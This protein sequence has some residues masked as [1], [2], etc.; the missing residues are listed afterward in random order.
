M[1]KESSQ[2][3]YFRRINR[4]IDYIADH[5]EKELSVEE[6]A[7]LSC[8]SHYHFH[9]IFKALVGES[10]G[11]YQRRIRVEKSAYMLRFNPSRS[12]TDIALSLGFNS[13]SAF[14]RAFKRHFGHSPSQERKSVFYNKKQADRSSS[15]QK[16][17]VIKE[18]SVRQL[19]PQRVYFHRYV[20][21]FKNNTVRESWCR[22]IQAA[23][24]KGMVNSES[25]FFGIV[26]DDPDITDDSLCRY[27]CC[28]SADMPLS[29]DI[30]EI[31]G[32]TF[33]V[34]EFEGDIIDGPFKA[35][36]WIY[37]VWFPENSYEPRE[38]PAY[39]DYYDFKEGINITSDSIM[40]YRICIPVKRLTL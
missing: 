1:I 35:Y 17:D 40:K 32:G 3:E 34:F 18:W 24:E 20:G 4:V 28:I 11:T 15:E 29:D 37:G 7:T 2:S 12:I 21:S 38:L 39:D 27:D 22:H 13:S 23:M 9:R 8:F 14:T 16:P 5:P 10:V 6:L 26:H 19:K 30:K 25:R 31:P 33:A 36:Q